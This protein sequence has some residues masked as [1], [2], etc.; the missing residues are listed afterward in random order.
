M[1]RDVDQSEIERAEIRAI[2]A[3]YPEAHAALRNW[4]AWSRD[5]YKIGPRD[6]RPGMWD[7]AIPS[8]F[9]DF[10]DET[11]E[12]EVREQV[13]VKAEAAAKEP[14]DEKSGCELDARIHGNGGLA[15]YQRNAIRIAYVSRETP[16][17]QFHRFAGCLPSTFRE[18]LI[19][20]LVFV[21]RHV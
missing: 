8:K 11:D 12:P 16:E 15:E 19:E 14:Y 9:G 6:A 18:R 21:G 2:Q 3:L 1:K 20:C 5:R 10:A 7:E 17:D 13:E 4:G